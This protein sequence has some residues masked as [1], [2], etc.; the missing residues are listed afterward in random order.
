MST[1]TQFVGGG[2]GV[3][4]VQ[5]GFAVFNLSNFVF[6]A[7]NN[8]ANGMRQDITL[9]PAVNVSKATLSFS[10]SVGT[11]APTFTN[12]FVHVRGTILSA[13]TVRLIVGNVSSTFSISQSAALIN[14]EVVEFE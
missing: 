6:S 2:G 5:R 8:A 13:V 14:W 11:A 12:D 1:L 4:G 10:L 3:K 7:A 9:S